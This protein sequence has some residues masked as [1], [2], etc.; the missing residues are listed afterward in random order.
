MIAHD[1]GTR[2]IGAVNMQEPLLMATGGMTMA[3]TV[4]GTRVLRTRHT[5]LATPPTIGPVRKTGHRI[6]R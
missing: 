5:S 3:R 4:T 6:R 1:Q 2:V